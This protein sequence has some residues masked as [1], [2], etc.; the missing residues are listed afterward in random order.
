MEGEKL[1]RAYYS[2]YGLALE[3]EVEMQVLLQISELD[4]NRYEDE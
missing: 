3:S 2:V 4:F 1:K